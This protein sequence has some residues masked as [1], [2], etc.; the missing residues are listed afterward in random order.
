MTE[1]QPEYVWAASPEKPKRSKVWLIVVLAVVA[2]AIAVAV[3]F[4]FFRPGISG[5]EPAPTPS[6]SPSDSVSPSA[7]PSASTSATPTTVPSTAPPT[8]APEPAD[9]DLPVFRDKVAPVL[10]D[11]ERGLD[12]AHDSPAQEA[13]Q[14]IGF[15]QEDAGRLANMVAPSS[16]APRWSSAVGTY[17]EA[18]QALRSAYERGSAAEQESS[19]A[20][21]ALD[22]L[23]EIVGLP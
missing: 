10:S 1:P 21:S 13:A 2:V 19:A 17:A 7:S 11:G 23:N 8:T 9:P 14:T 12:I 5:A 20:R 15:L 6:T 22:K 4:I 3:L 16:I 18:L